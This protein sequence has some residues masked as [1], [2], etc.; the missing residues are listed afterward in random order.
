VKNDREY[1]IMDKLTD[2]EFRNVLTI[3]YEY[4]DTLHCIF[5]DTIADTV[6][7]MYHK[8]NSFAQID[9]L[10]ELDEGCA[11]HEYKARYELVAS[12][13]EAALIDVFGEEVKS[14][15]PIFMF[16]INI[17]E[18]LFKEI[19]RKISQR[20]KNYYRT[21]RKEELLPLFE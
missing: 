3:V 11:E 14:Q 18:I 5:G 7:E 10:L 12:C 21:R 15:M 2:S 1:N 13:I 20:S 6:I 19:D 17:D 16:D 4:L 9:I 8:D